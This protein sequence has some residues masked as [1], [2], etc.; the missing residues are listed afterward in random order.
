VAA[1]TSP[2]RTKDELLDLARRLDV[3]GRSSMTKDELG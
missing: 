2:G 3:P 1:S